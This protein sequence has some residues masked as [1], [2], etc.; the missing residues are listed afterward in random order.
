M[1]DADD[2]DVEIVESEEIERVD[3]LQ[4]QKK[5]V[6]LFSVVL[7]SSVVAIIG[8]V[9]GAYG[10][11]YLAKTPDLSAIDNQI[12]LK[13]A[14]IE[15]KTQKSVAALRTELD[16]LKTDIM[17]VQGGQAS[18]QVL[19]SLQNRLEALENAPLPEIPDIDA[20]AVSALQRAQAD[21]FNWPDL[22]EIDANIS[23]LEKEHADLTDRLQNISEEF[24]TFKEA[25]ID[26]V[27][28][29]GEAA[30]EPIMITQTLTLPIF[31]E[32]ALRKSAEEAVS[33]KGFLA[34][35]L[36]KH[37]DVRQPNDPIVLIEKAALAVKSGNLD[38]AVKTFDQL[39]DEI[40]VAGQDWRDAVGNP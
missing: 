28:L 8:A 9:G 16:V 29:G 20:D 40:K 21:G 19:A 37:I 31:P 25:P 2:I 3:T 4:T 23:R 39:P 11:Q 30:P 34:R 33:R 22:T 35:T 26:V 12:S 14:D 7:L 24:E 5:G 1:E 10:A 38:L 32:M 27:A 18:E 15:D 36:S 13:V 6:G 17:D